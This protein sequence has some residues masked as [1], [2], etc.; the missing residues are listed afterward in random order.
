MIQEI[1]IRKTGIQE[2]GVQEM[3]QGIQKIGPGNDIF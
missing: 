2:T 1:G 3:I